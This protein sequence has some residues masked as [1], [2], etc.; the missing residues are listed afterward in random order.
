MSGLTDL[1]RRLAFTRSETGVI[2]LLAA[3]LVAGTLLRLI[4][5]REAP[6]AAPAF[7]YTAA[8]SVFRALADTAAGGAPRSAP[9]GR[10]PHR[11]APPPRLPVDLNNASPADLVRLPGV[12]AATAGRIVEARTRA[13]GFRRVEDLL[14]VR[15]IGRKKLDALRPY[16]TVR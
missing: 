8:D 2:L 1:Q 9:S 3:G 12:G 10:A 11:K 5:P 14:G 15:G 4:G 7:D 6:D 13:G 16:V